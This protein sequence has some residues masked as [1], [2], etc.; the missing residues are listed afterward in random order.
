[1]EEKIGEMTDNTNNFSTQVR[2]LVSRKAI[3]IGVVSTVLGIAILIILA[4]TMY[5]EDVKPVVEATVNA[6]NGDVAIVYGGSLHKGFVVESFDK[7]GGKLFNKNFYDIDANDVKIK[8]FGNDLHLSYI[9][10]GKV[11]YYVYSRDGIDVEYTPTDTDF[12]NLS[13]RMSWEQSIGNQTYTR[14]G[15]IYTWEKQNV[16]DYTV[17]FSISHD[18]KTIVIY[19]SSRRE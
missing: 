15:Y 4:L 3:I 16:F 17:E 8:F 14:D 5:S 9:K 1:M 7:E 11:F 12:S 18:G 19:R 2:E 13:Q 10:G 6:E